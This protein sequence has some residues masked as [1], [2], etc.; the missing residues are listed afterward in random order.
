M[1]WGGI[2][3]VGYPKQDICGRNYRKSNGY[4]N[5]EQQFGSRSE[6]R[7]LS[8]FSCTQHL[9]FFLLSPSH[10]LLITSEKATSCLVRKR[11]RGKKRWEHRVFSFPSFSHKTACY[12]FKSYQEK[13]KS[14]R[15]I[16]Q[17]VV[18]IIR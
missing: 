17:A 8:A 1:I 18:T 14:R 4:Y 12:F 7:Q 16:W 6:W 13:M 11:G 10:D 15:R 9:V 5:H 2:A 3:F